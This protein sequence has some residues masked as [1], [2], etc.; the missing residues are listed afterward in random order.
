MIVKCSIMFTSLVINF[1]RVAF[2]VG[3]VRLVNQGFYPENRCVLRV[4][5]RLMRAMRVLQ[6]N[7]AVGHKTETGSWKA[8]K[9]S[10]ELRGNAV[11]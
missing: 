7:K 2:D 11:W 10:I 5:T 6:N 3:Q 4:E 1:I 8:L 9:S